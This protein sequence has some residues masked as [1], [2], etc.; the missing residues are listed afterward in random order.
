MTATFYTDFGSNCVTINWVKFDYDQESKA[1]SYKG[2]PVDAKCVAASNGLPYI[3]FADIPA[4][5]RTLHILDYYHLRNVYFF[6]DKDISPPCGDISNPRTFKRPFYYDLRPDIYFSSGKYDDIIRVFDETFSTMRMKRNS[7]Y[8]ILKYN[9]KHD[10][11]VKIFFADDETG[12]IIELEYFDRDY[13]NFRE[14]KTLFKA[15]LSTISGDTI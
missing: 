7:H 2:T 11:N 13:E 8:Y 10:I 14:F 5:K 3:E 4:L 6:K 15:A 9:E 1:F 12:Y